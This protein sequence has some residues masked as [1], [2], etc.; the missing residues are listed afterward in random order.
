MASRGIVA[1]DPETMTVAEQIRLFRGA[2]LIVGSHGAGLTNMIFSDHAS[3]VELF[4][5]WKSLCYSAIAIGFG[6]DYSGIDLMPSAG[7]QAGDVGR[8]LDFH[9]NI[10]VVRSALE[11]ALKT[12]HA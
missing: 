12:A 9:A 5:P 2:R 10:D 4:G 11:S 1:V 6:H 7:F 8:S 3:I